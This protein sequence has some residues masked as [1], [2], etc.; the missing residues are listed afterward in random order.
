MVKEN[1]T[2]Q[3]LTQ[4]Q[5]A[6]QLQVNRQTLWRW[7]KAGVIKSVSVGRVKRYPSDTADKLKNR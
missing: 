4:A 2:Q 5:L 1:M 3:F 6:A 7:E